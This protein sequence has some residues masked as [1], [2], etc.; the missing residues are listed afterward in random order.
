MVQEYYNK[1]NTW[2]L[3]PYLTTVMEA[4]NLLESC[5]NKIFLFRMEKNVL[6]N[7]STTTNILR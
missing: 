7:E 5:C 4:L 6:V 3:L 2:K 1:G